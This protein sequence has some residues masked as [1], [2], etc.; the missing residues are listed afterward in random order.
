[1]IRRRVFEMKTSDR[2]RQN[3]KIRNLTNQRFVILIFDGM[4]TRT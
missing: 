3:E 1:M 2:R 4:S